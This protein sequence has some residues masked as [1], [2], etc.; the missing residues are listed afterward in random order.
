VTVTKTDG[1]EAQVIRSVKC[2]LGHRVLAEQPDRQHGWN[3]TVLT[4][5]PRT[6][7]PFGLL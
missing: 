2:V 1:T 4:V 5:S 7:P 3:E 6:P